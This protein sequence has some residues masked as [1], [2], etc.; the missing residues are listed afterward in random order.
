MV[1]IDVKSEGKL[2]A[3]FILH[4]VFQV[5]GIHRLVIIY[6]NLLNIVKIEL[7]SQALPPVHVWAI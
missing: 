2:N 4:T 5:K 6:I 7:F 3:E 1:G